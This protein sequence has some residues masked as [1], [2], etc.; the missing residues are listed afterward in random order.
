MA[1]AAGLEL[2]GTVAADGR[3]VAAWEDPGAAPRS[4]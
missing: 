1:L 3:I 2:P 4:A